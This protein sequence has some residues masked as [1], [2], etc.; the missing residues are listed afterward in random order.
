MT[1]ERDCEKKGET[2]FWNSLVFT[3]PKGCTGLIR[4]IQGR[5]WAAFLVGPLFVG[6][7]GGVMSG[8]EDCIWTR[9]KCWVGDAEPR[10]NAA[11]L[12]VIATGGKIRGHTCRA[13]C[14]LR[15]FLMLCTLTGHPCPRLS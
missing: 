4:I 12:A 10:D 11:F 7:G 8:R 9:W 1:I 3:L 2:F 14:W 13:D 15:R 5:F 6:K